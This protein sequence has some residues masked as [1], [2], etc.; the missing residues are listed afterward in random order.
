MN[1]VTTIKPHIQQINA[2]DALRTLQCWLIW[3]Y[4]HHDK[5]AKPRKMPYY[6]SGSPRRGVHGNPEDRA[7]L[8]TFD[9][10]KA[11]AAR[12]G[13]DGVGFCPLPE[14]GI[15]AGDFD[16]CVGADGI[17]P[18]VEVMVAGTYT[19]YSPSGKGIRAFW[20]GNLG[21]RKTQSGGGPFGFETFS[22]NGFVT[23]TGNVTEMCSLLGAENIVAPISAEL[24]QHYQ[25]RFGAY[26]DPAE[27]DPLLTHAPVVGL[28]DGQIREALDVLPRDLSYDEWL[29]IGMAVHH[30]TGG[31]DAGFELWNEWNKLSPKNGTVK[32]NM[33]R[34]RSFGERE[35]HAPVTARSLLKL[36][37]THGYHVNVELASESDFDL[38]TVA[39]TKPIRF[40][41]V[42]AGEFS[43]GKHPGWIIKGILPSGDLI[44]VYGDSGSGKT[45]AVLDM[46]M[47]ISRGVDWRGR[48]V[49]QGRVIYIAA[50]GGGGFRKRLAAYAQHHGLELDDLPFGVIHAAPNFLLKDD[51]LDVARAVE[52]AGGADVIVVDTFAQ[53]MPGGNEN[54][55]EDMGKALAHC[56]GIGRKTGAVMIMVHH[57]GKDS[58]KGA[59]GWSGLRAAADAQIEILKS[60]TGTRVIRVDKQ[61]DGDDQVELGFDLEIVPIGIDEDGDVIDSCVVVEAS[62]PV[63]GK[64][65]DGRRK[66]MG[67]WERRVMEVVSEFAIGQSAGIEVKAVVEEVARRS[68]A[69]ESGRRDARKQHAKRAL[70]GLCDGPDAPFWI[71]DDCL[72]MI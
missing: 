44:V 21:N 55:G 40:Q 64:G 52:A 51:A 13:Y 45:F 58:S 35:G 49:H 15:V 53:V 26:N 71:E 72:A 11:A 62:M 39:D 38:V 31:T 32:Y 30:E 14:L 60:P 17:S 22:T 36:A 48:K 27:G 47:A 16:N 33:D 5:E 54:S 61:K 1:A 20:L 23:F 18:L 4:E 65:T 19:E 6:A 67:E 24:H 69:P 7:Q 25:T 2:P 46:A 8:V 41:V 56:R 10:A 28:T 9:A 29:A 70:M 68:P 12:R 66:P 57:S 50:E 63:M 42:S 3:R 34:W 59:R 43:R 37:K